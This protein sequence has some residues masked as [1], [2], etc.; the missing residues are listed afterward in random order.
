MLNSRVLTLIIF[1]TAWG[2]MDT[3]F[4][5]PPSIS[6]QIQD[7][8]QVQAQRRERQLQG[9]ERL[10]DELNTT[11]EQQKKMQDIH[12]RYKNEIAGH[13]QRLVQLQQELNTLMIGNAS[14]PEI[15]R[16]H[17]ELEQVRQGMTQLQLDMLL[18]MREVLTPEQRDQ[19]TEIMQQRQIRPHGDR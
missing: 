15:R 10:L 2:E 18:R 1:L 7:L 5:N 11:A 17:D 19:F 8:V 3:A 13:R 14:E 6:T 4:A 16:K 12:N 9:P